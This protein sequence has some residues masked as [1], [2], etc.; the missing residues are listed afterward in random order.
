MRSTVNWARGF[1][2]S[3]GRT[4]LFI[5]VLLGLAGMTGCGS[6][7]TEVELPKDFIRDFIAKHETMVDKSLVYYYAREEQD[8]VAEQIDIACRICKS[9]GT[10]ETLQQATFDFSGLKIQLVD[11][12]SEYVADEPVVFVKVAIKGNY[13]MKLSEENRTIETDDVIVLRMARN[14]WKVT[15][16]NNPW[17]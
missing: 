5:F 4:L 15:E 1:R 17:S 13:T 8:R 12:K 14:E 2:A 7:I 16:N 3:A 9:K 10:L 6:S 11:K